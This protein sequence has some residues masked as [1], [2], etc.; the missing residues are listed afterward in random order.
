[1]A[2][3]TAGPEGAAKALAASKKLMEG[4]KGGSLGTKSGHLEGPKPPVHPDASKASYQLATD[5][6]KA[7]KEPSNIVPAGDTSGQELKQAEENANQLREAA[8]PQP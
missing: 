2:Q 5:A 8:K 1:M 3:D 6:R 7:A 4:W